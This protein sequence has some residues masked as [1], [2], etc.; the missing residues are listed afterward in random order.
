[1]GLDI[2]PLDPADDIAIDQ[3]IELQNAATAVDNPDFPPACR[4]S[5]AGA[6]RNPVGWTRRE[7]RVAL[8]GDRIVGYLVISLPLRDN[9]ENSEVELVVH[10][11]HRRQGVGRAL[12]AYTLDLLRADGRKRLAA[13]TDDA[14][15]R[16]AFATAMGAQA[17]L[18][19]WRRRLDLSTI[20]D[21]VNARLL[22]AAWQKAAGYQLVQWRNA[23]PEDYARDVNY[24]DAR[25]ATDAPLGDLIWEPPQ[26][27]TARMRESE[28]VR[29]KRGIR[30]YGTGVVHEESGRLVAVSELGMVRTT[31]WHAWQWLTIVDPDHRGHRLGTIVK[32][33]N[34]THARRGEP[35]LRIVDTWNATVNAHMIS[36]NEAMGF[37]PVERWINWQQEV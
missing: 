36:I 26:V 5:L 35:A 12:H 22:A 8:A 7:Y 27:D 19:E 10:P 20:D 4:Y 17:A 25:M 2:V 29:A 1:M 32:V 30:S 9:T 21:E 3:V 23:V 28:R 33:E 31:D 14:P 13:G 11:A 34:L 16:T 6:L 24:L 15:H 18:P 37:R